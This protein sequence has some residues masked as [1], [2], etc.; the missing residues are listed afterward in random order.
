VTTV[1]SYREFDPP[2]E[3][4]H[5]V[6]CVWEQHVVADRVQRVL[7]DG[8][9]DVLLHDS[10]LVEVVGLADEAALPR[11][12]AGTQLRGIR[13]RPE[14]VASALQV[15]AAS[16]R[17]Q[18][19]PADDVL[20]TRR[21]RSLFDARALDSWLR[22]VRPDGLAAAALRLLTSHSVASTADQ[23]GVSERQLRRI[24]AT[25]TGLT[26][27]AFQRVARLRTFLREAERG[28]PLAAAAAMSGYADQ[29]H[30]TREVRALSGLTPARL[31]T[32][33]AA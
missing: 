18:T 21:A 24:L 3:W 8:H 16:L 13:L 33:R 15:D 11:L 7:P 4:R 10:G 14:A 27:K 12:P 2:P 5:A 26:P 32:E 28:A 29:S 22:S 25:T 1:D 30:L 23:V 6:A 19:I 17:N 31:L 9:G 20:G